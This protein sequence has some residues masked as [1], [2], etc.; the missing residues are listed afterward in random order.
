M[1]EA[2]LSSTKPADQRHTQMIEA[3][4]KRSILVVPPEKEVGASLGRKVCNLC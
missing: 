3:S 2:A 4:A 1:E